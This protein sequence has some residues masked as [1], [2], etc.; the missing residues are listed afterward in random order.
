[1]L[2][3]ST[4]ANQTVEREFMA[5]AKG[6]DLAGKLRT[7]RETRAQDREKFAAQSDDCGMHAS[8]LVTVRGRGGLYDCHDAGLHRLGQFR[9]GRQQSGQVEVGEGSTITGRAKV[10]RGHA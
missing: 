6:V 5:W 4:E 2:A 10:L 9:P 8:P 3:D 1:M 7:M